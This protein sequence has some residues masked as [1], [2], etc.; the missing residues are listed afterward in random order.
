[1]TIHLWQP[2]TGEPLTVWRC[3]CGTIELGTPTSPCPTQPR[4]HPRSMIGAPAEPRTSYGLHAWTP[5]SQDEA[6]AYVE[7]LRC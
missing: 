2:G 5:V 4:A 3:T 1:M 7:S 6:D